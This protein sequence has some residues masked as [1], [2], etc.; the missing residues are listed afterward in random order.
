MRLLVCGKTLEFDVQVK[1]P[2]GNDFHPRAKRAV[3]RV[4]DPQ[5]VFS[6]DDGVAVPLGG[7][8][9]SAADHAAIHIYP[10]PHWH[11]PKNQI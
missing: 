8:S 3:A 2:I 11:H 9:L 7:E 6:L 4:F 5:V 1:C 10:S